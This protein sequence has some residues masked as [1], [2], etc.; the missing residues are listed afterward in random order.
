MS[1]I[2]HA[3]RAARRLG[4]VVAAGAAVTALP[5][6]VRSVRGDGASIGRPWLVLTPTR[7]PL[8][9]AGWFAAMKAAWRPL[10]IRL[11]TAARWTALVGGL[12]MYLS[13]MSLAVY[14]RLALGSSYRPSTTL[15]ATLAPDR[16]VTT[17]PFAIV[18]H[19]MYLGLMVAAIG[20]TG[21]YR[22]WSTLWFVMQLPVLVVR[23]RREDALLARTF[24]DAWTA[25]AAAAPA[26]LPF[27]QPGRS[28]GGRMTR[29]SVDRWL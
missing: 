13:G 10:P 12:A 27:A 26:W 28:E 3:E 14:G 1:R 16:L 5:G 8:V 23:A 24:G 4:A 21:L 29:Q 11:G 25:Y 19:P 2:D 18:R 20:S 7:V 22:T 6:L 9:G 15:G 17:G